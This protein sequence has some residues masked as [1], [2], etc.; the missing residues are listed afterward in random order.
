MINF[1]FSISR[2]VQWKLRIWKILWVTFILE[3]KQIGEVDFYL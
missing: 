2:Y 3:F 1:F